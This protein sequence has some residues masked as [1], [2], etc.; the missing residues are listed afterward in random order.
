MSEVYPQWLLP[1][2]TTFTPNP[3]LPTRCQVCNVGPFPEA[4]VRNERTNSPYVYPAL[5]GCVVGSH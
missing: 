3:G 1:G 2:S 4:E 5:M